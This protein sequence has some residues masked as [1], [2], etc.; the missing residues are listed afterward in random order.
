MIYVSVDL[1]TTG[2]DTQNDQILEFGAI[3]DD[4]RPLEELPRFH[5][6]VRHTRLEGSPYALWMN[7]EIVGALANEKNYPEY[8]FTHEP[9]LIFEFLRFLDQIGHPKQHVSFAGKNF[10][11]FD[12]RFLERLP[13]WADVKYRHRIIDPAILYAEP[14]DSRLPDMKTC[15]ERAGITGGVAHTAIEDALVVIK[16]LRHKWTQG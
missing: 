2:L 7:R 14:G 13:C 5:R 6:Y 4:G 12:L 1:E 8:L 3:I 11:T 10:G 15:M 9:S 16:L